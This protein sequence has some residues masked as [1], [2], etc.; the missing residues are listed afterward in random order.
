MDRPRW[1]CV[2]TRQVIWGIDCHPFFFFFFLMF[3]YLIYLAVPGFSCGT[4]DLHCH[5]RDLFS[6]GLWDV[7]P[8]PGME[9]GPLHWE[10]GTLTTGPPSL[11]HPFFFFLHLVLSLFPTLCLESGTFPS[12]F[13]KCLCLGQSSESSVPPPSP[14]GACVYRR[15]IIEP[16]AEPGQA[17]RVSGGSTALLVSCRLSGTIPT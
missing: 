10:H 16:N 17:G 2:Q 14:S 6:C 9:P 3:T 11:C 12:G 13:T 15:R 5:M 8:W 7:V 4:W 1:F